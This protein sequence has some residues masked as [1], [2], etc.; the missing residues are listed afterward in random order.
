MRTAIGI[1]IA[2]MNQHV[3]GGAAPAPP[4]ALALDAFTQGT[5]VGATSLTIS[6]VVG[7]ASG[8]RL[9]RVVVSWIDPTGL[10]L[11][12]QVSSVKYNGVDLTLLAG[13][14]IVTTSGNT[15]KTYYLLNP[16]S[17][18]HNVVVTMSDLLNIEATVDSWDGV[19]QTTPFGTP[20]TNFGTGTSASVS[21]AIA[22]GNRAL[23][24]NLMFAGSST[25]SAT[26]QGN[27]TALGVAF[28]SGTPNRLRLSS[29]QNAVDSGTV[30]PTWTITS[31][32]WAICAVELKAA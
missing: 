27:L 15:Q 20:A 23:A 6:H 30:T 31:K 28:L 5:V 29:G 17:G 21:V 9:M 25:T 22:A 32:P 24:S 8:Y 2:L 3:V 11:D 14:T 12:P 13:S 26:P 19:N 18:T 1:S 7:A 4:P 10:L 16:A